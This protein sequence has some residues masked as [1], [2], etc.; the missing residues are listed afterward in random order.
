MAFVVSIEIAAVN[1]VTIDCHEK[2]RGPHFMNDTLLKK[3]KGPDISV[4][5]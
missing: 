4:A 3:L 5:T 2:E 1:V